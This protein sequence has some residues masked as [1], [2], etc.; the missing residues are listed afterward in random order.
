[1]KPHNTVSPSGHIFYFSKVFTSRHGGSLFAQWLIPTL[2]DDGYSVTLISENLGDISSF[3]ANPRL[4][5]FQTPS[6]FQRGF[7]NVFHKAREIISICRMI[8]AA[9]G[10]IVVVQGDLPRVTYLFLQLFVPLLFW[11]QDGILTCPANNRFLPRSRQVCR[12]PLGVS[13]LAVNRIEGCL[14]GLSLAKRLGRIVFRLRD[15]YLLK[16]IR[17]FIATSEYISRVHQK[18]ASI[19]YPACY[20]TA[21]QLADSERNLNRIVF[22]ARL[23][24]VK[25]CD[26]TIRILAR[27]PREYFLEIVSD[28]PCMDSLKQLALDLGVHDRV[29]FHG[30]VSLEERDRILASAG[31]FLMTSLWDEAF[32]MTGFEAFL[33][34]TPVVAYDVG[35]VAEWCRAPAGVLVGCGD[36]GAAA[37]AVLALTR[38]VSG[39]NEASHQAVSISQEFGVDIFKE[40]F[41]RLMAEAS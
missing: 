27:L 9:P 20:G 4:N 38:N 34:G 17:N 24:V 25:G 6:F 36:V 21:S 8:F 14:G 5:V 15:Y 2:L 39:W 18:K 28:G 7:L 3:S 1:M 33:Q 35:G 31:V 29:T 12:K 40:N 11:R 41:K 37:D 26:E 19:L 30:W 16:M 32:G 10:S 23:E 13:C 22:C